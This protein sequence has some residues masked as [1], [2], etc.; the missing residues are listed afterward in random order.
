M[1]YSNYSQ[2]E[3]AIRAR[4]PFTGNSSRGYY[5]GEEYVVVSY[6]T[7][8]ARATSVRVVGATWAECPGGLYINTRKYSQTTTRLQNIVKRA[9]GL[10]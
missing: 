3:S 2:I 7:A 9:W 1:S 8:I 6:N 10:N 4:V 5:E